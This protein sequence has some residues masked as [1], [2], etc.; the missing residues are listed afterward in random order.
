VVSDVEVAE[1]NRRTIVLEP[2][3]VERWEEIGGERI[4][5]KVSL[6]KSRRETDREVATRLLKAQTG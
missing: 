6:G 4:P 3:K 5:A 1:A 2:M